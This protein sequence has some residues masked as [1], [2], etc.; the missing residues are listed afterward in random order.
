[1]KV[2]YHHYQDLVVHGRLSSESPV[3]AERT[4]DYAT[5]VGTYL[6][7]VRS[8][9]PASLPGFN[10]TLLHDSIARLN[11]VAVEFDS[12]A[13]PLEGCVQQHRSWWYFRTEYRLQSRIRAINQVYI[14]FEHMFYYEPGLDGGPWSKHVVFSESAWHKYT[15]V[16][17]ALEIPCQ[18][19]IPPR[20]V[21]ELL[22]LCS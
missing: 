10:F 8:Q 12:Y 22:S 16:F 21:Y 1:M 4:T 17:P 3:L 11:Q 15:G 9:V 2:S 19:E 5:S 20:L 6:R 18:R 14:A 13:A 7:P